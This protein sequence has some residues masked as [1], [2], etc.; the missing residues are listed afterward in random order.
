MEQLT[1]SYKESHLGRRCPAYDGR[2]SLYTAGALPFDSKE[3][4]VKLMDEDRNRGS[5]SSAR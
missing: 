3:F 5:S 2:K 4:V 1:K